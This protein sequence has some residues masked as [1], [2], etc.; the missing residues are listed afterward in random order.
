MADLVTRPGRRPQDGERRAQRGPRPA[1]PPG[2]H[3]RRPAVA[4]A[5]GSP[6][7]TDPVKVEIELNPMVPAAERGEFSLRLILH[8]RR[9]CLA[10]TP[11]CGDCVLARL[12]PVVNPSQTGPFARALDARTSRKRRS[13]VPAKNR[14]RI[15]LTADQV[16]ATW[17][18]AT[19]GSAAW[20]RT[21]R[22]PLRGALVPF[23]RDAVP[24][25]LRSPTATARP[26]RDR[27]SAARA[28]PRTSAAAASSVGDSVAGRRRPRLT[29]SA[30]SRAAVRADRARRCDVVIGRVSQASPFPLAASGSTGARRYRRRCAAP[31]RPAGRDLGDPSERVRL[32][33]P[34]RPAPSPVAAVRAILAEVRAGGDAASAS[35]PSASTASRLD[36]LRVPARR[37]RRGPRRARPGAAGGAR[38]GGRR[39][40][41]LPPA[42][43]RRPTAPTE[44]DG[45]VVEGLHRPVDR[46]GLLRARRSGRLPVHRADDRHPGPGRR[47]ARGRAV[48]A[49]RTPT[50]EVPGGDAGRGRARRRRRGVPDRRRPGDRR[51][52]LRHRVDPAGR[53]HRR[54]GQRLRGRGQAGGGRRGSVGVPSAFA[55]PSEVVVVADDTVDRR[56][57][58]PSTSSCRPSTAPT[59]W[60][61]SSPGTRRSPTPSSPRS[62]AQVAASPRRADIESTL[63]RAAATRCVVDGPEQAIAVANLI[64]PEHL[65]LLYR[66]PRGAGAARPPRRRG[67][68]RA[69]GAGLGR[70]LRRRAEPR[71]AHLRLGPLRRRRS[72]CDDF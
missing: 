3:P 30:S 28:R 36:D 19:P 35:S 72:P 20:C 50:G 38:G 51:H 64:A 15:W 70:R 37:A 13:N 61:G 4:G 58:P 43:A 14:V 55:G 39:H 40:R 45:I 66:R 52:G 56:P 31:A 62:T 42:P 12:L 24:S 54:A 32:P 63:R 16:P 71:A 44:R 21:T 57:A 68:L 67:V 8:G 69:V 47:R 49:A 23:S 65:E 6:T 60:P 2:R 17:F 26:T 27:A 29:R 34:S 22:A 33:R 53:R 25:G 41:G 5:S 48:R 9:V 7:E 1:R 10:R 46:A 59:A 11:R 18:L